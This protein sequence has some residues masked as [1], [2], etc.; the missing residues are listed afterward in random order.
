[1]QFRIFTAERDNQRA[2]I[3]FMRVAVGG[4]ALALLANA[5]ALLSVAG[6]ER[7]VLNRLESILSLLRRP[8]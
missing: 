5:A 2:E 3:T 8:L 6:S 7:T 4:L 1:M